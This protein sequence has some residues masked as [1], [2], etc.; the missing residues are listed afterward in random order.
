MPLTLRP[1]NHEDDFWRVR[2]FLREVSLINGRR[3]WS[4]PVVRWDYWY[5]HI[6]E[7]IFHF[8]LP[9]VVWVWEEAGQIAAVVN[10]DGPGE[11][12]FQVHPAR[13]CPALETEMLDVAEARLTT[14]EDGQRGLTVWVPAH[15]KARQQRAAARGFQPAGTPEHQRRRRLGGPIPAVPL[16]PG[17]TLRPVGDEPDL[18]ARSWVSWKAFHPNEPDVRYEGW[19]WYRNVQRAPLYRRDLDLVAV[20]P[21]GE[22]ASFCTVWLDDVTRTAVFE[23]VGTHPAHQ[24]RGLGKAVMAEGLRRAERLGATLATVGSYSAAAHALYASM[25]FTEFDLSVPWRKIY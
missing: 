11:A 13:G 5:W 25:G 20:A 12:F 17:Y 8:E 4:W 18:P 22:H 6:H 3:D 24:K 7:N 2:A 16:A 10:P 9:E 23:P 15:D 1:Y 14:V 21:D 19:T